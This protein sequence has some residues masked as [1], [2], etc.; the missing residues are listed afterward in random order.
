[1]P[2][3]PRPDTPLPFRLRAALAAP[4]GWPPDVLPNQV[5]TAAH[6]NAIRDSVYQWPGDVNGGNHTLSNVNRVNAT[7]VLADPTTTAGDLI[8]RGAA[9]LGRFP[10]GAA[11]QVLTVDLALPGKLK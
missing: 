4:A 10:I 7:G 5:I 6:I 2:D 8:S 1:M 11:G 9:T 3:T